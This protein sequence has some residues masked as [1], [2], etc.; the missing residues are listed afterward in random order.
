[1]DRGLLSSATVLLVKRRSHGLIAAAT[2]LV[3]LDAHGYCRKTTCETCPL[4]LVT[5]CPMGGQ[6]L[7]WPNACVSFAVSRRPSAVVSTSDLE[8]ITTQAFETWQSATC[9]GLGEPPSIHIAEADGRTSCGLAEYS[10][11]GANANVI[12]VRDGEWP[13]EDGEDSILALTS[14]SFDSVTGEILDADIEV[15]G[16]QTLSVTDA[17]PPEGYDLLS[18]LT[19]ET[20]HFLGLAHSQDNDA[21]MRHAYGGGTESLRVLTEDDIAGICAIY[22]SERRALKCNFTPHGGF[23]SECPLGVY[24]GGCT[25]A[26]PS[27]SPGA[28]VSLVLI[29]AAVAVRRRFR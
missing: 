3:A 18:I 13:Y 7:V 4:D 21:V 15:N 19:H 6:P 25:V 5:G 24:K 8:R 1:V 9:P 23:A 17:L 28:L 11:T 20:G 12:L 26:P 10:R 27:R 29:G 14:V 16:L 22:P 2:L